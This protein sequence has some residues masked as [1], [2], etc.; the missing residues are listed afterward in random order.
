[1][2]QGEDVA[3]ATERLRGSLALVGLGDTLRPQSTQPGDP[4]LILDCIP[5]PET[6]GRVA[7]LGLAAIGLNEGD[8]VIHE[9]NGELDMDAVKYYRRTHL[10]QRLE[11]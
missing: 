11:R 6:L 4:C 10:R 3:G 1:M 9:F 8:R 7:D 5:Q 2:L